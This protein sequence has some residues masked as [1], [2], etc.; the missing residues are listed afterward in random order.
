MA[1]IGER[2]QSVTNNPLNQST[3]KQQFSFSKA[4][5]FHDTL[6][7]DANIGYLNLPSTKTSRTTTFGFGNKMLSSLKSESPP[8][9]TYKLPSDFDVK[10]KKGKVYSFRCS[11]KAYSKVYQK[12][13]FNNTKGADPNVPGPGTYK[14]WS[15][16]GK[17]G[18]KFTLK[19]KLKS[20]P[21]C[22]DVPG[23]GAYAE[24]TTIPKSGRNFY[25]RFKS[26]NSGS[27]G[28][29]S[30]SRF[31]DDT[32]K[33]RDVPGPG[34]YTPRTGLA[35]TGQ[36]F[37]SKF[38]SSGSTVLA[39]TSRLSTQRASTDGPGPGSYRL[40]SDFGYPTSLRVG[41]KKR[42]KM[43]RSASQL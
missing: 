32:K 26:I 9:G 28:P 27:I 43:R 36:Y 8:P 20:L 15:G 38:K 16:F 14:A 34:Q 12:E 4:D 40:P 25:S 18:K 30:S 31:Q 17:K 10:P 3:A 6:K 35:K 2:S 19:G 41:G 22:A 37:L 23:P 39:G 21:P 33:T 24:L 5:R 11:W 7:S 13:G 29:P 1:G 42:R